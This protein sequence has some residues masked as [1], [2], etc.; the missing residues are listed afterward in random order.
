MF[1]PPALACGWSDAHAPV[2]V[3]QQKTLLKALKTA[4]SAV[5]CTG[6]AVLLDMP[7]LPGQQ[8]QVTILSGRAPE[9]GS[10]VASLLVLGASISVLCCLQYLQCSLYCHVWLPWAAHNSVVFTGTSGSVE[11]TDLLPSKIPCLHRQHQKVCWYSDFPGAGA[12]GSVIRVI[13]GFFPQECPWKKPGASV[14]RTEQI[15]YRVRR[16]VEKETLKA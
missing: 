14:I 6:G 5:V 1:A 4:V 7:F 3:S 2:P 12:P 10:Q 16:K 9:H 11:D 13:Q 8:C 15:F